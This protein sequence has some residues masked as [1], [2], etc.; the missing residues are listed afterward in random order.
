MNHQAPFLTQ[1][2]DTCSPYGYRPV[3]KVFVDKKNSEVKKISNIS[4]SNENS[5]SVGQDSLSD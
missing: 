3:K 5:N 4:T 1:E 2:S